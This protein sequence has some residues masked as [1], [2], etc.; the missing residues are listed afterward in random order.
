VTPILARGPAIEGGIVVAPPVFGRFGGDLIAPNETSGPSS[1]S[2]RT[3][4]W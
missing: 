4:T 2:S 3:G 1:H